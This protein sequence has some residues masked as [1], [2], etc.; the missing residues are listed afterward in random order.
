M[1]NEALPQTVEHAGLVSLQ[2]LLPRFAGRDV[3]TGEI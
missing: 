3:L 2:S 1:T